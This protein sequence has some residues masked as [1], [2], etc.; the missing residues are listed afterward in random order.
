MQRQIF[1]LTIVTGIALAGCAQDVARQYQTVKV[2]YAYGAN[3]K[4]EREW[5]AKL[6]ALDACHM[7]GYQDAYPAGR[8]AIVCVQGS[9]G[10]C[11]HFR[12]SAS[13]DCVG[14]GYQTL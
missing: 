12:A 9:N 7:A 10:S 5:R 14:M 8:P 11:A 6:K 13:Y 2:S 4:S 1:L 3:D